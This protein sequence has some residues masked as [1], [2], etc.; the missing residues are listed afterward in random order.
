VVEDLGLARSRRRDEMLVENI[1]D[2]FANLRQLTLDLLSVT[3]NHGNLGLVTLGL[4]LL[5]N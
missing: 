4:L 5:L 3:L 2:I 1:E